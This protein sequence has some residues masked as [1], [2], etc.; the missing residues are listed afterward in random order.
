MICY[1]PPMHRRRGLC[2]RSAITAR[3]SGRAPAPSLLPY[4]STLPVPFRRRAARSG[5]HG[6]ADGWPRPC[7]CSVARIARRPITR[8][9]FATH[10][11][12]AGPAAGRC[13]LDRSQGLRALRN[14]RDMVGAYAPGSASLDRSGERSAAA[15]GRACVF[16]RPSKAVGS[17]GAAISYRGSRRASLADNCRGCRHGV[18]LRASRRSVGQTGRVPA[19]VGRRCG[20]SAFGGVSLEQ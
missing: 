12:V 14:D 17:V 19:D 6:G 8:G 4:P 13:L 2:A 3:P 20:R 18:H 9:Q 11:V 7:R 1:L 16:P 15:Q 5:R 10:P